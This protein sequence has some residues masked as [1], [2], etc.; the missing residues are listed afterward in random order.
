MEM[1][2]L[3]TESMPLAKGGTLAAK[4]MT[5]APKVFVLQTMTQDGNTERAHGTHTYI[6]S[7]LM[8]ISFF[9]LPFFLFS[10]CLFV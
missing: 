4:K 8:K 5:P 7:W 1:F 2:Y 3:G 6:S 9:L 10:F